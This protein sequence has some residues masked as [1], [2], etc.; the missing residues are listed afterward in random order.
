VGRETNRAYLEIQIIEQLSQLSQRCT[1][2]VHWADLVAGI[3]FNHL[4]LQPRGRLERLTQR[5]PQT[6]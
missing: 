4:G 5:K 2:N 6:C 3:Y 1:R